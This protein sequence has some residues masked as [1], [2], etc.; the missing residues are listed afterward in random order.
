MS[1]PAWDHDADI[2]IVGGGSAGAVLAGRL[3]EDPATQVLL[4]EAGRSGR[5]PL[6]LVPGAQ[7]FVRDW[8]RHAWAYDIEPDPT[9]LGRT[10]TWRRGKSLGGSST[11][12]G[13]I[14]ARGLPSDFDRWAAAGLPQWSFEK[15]LP[16]FRRMEASADFPHSPLR[17][18]GGPVPVEVLRSA[19]VLA[20]DLLASAQ[21]MG[22]P[23][24]ADAN[25]MQGEG[26]GLAQT[27]QQR[28]LRVSSETS[29]LQPARRRQNLRVLTDATALRILFDGRR[30]EGVEIDLG[31][32]R[33]RVRA[34]R[35]TVLSAGPIASP[36]LLARSGV[37][38]G[39]ALQA[40]G[41]PVVAD[42][43]DVGAHLQDHPDVYVEY[44]VRVPTYSSAL[45]GANLVKAGLQF[46]L[47]RDGPA[48]SP[49]THVLGYLKSRP[50]EPEP[51][52][53]FFSG[54]WSRIEDGGTFTSPRAVMSM[55]PSLCR[56]RSRGCISLR[57]ADPT[58]P[59][60]IQANML[61][62]AD[63]IRRLIAGVRLADRLAMTAPLCDQVIRRLTP[64]AS[65]LDDDT[66]LEAWLRAD[67]TT[68]YHACGTCRMGADAASV[69]D[70]ELRVRGVNKLR[71]VDSSVFPEIPSG[72]LN[73]PTV[74]LA[75]R[76]ADLM[77]QAL[78]GD[79]MRES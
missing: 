22:I 2:V 8:S 36:S 54:P 56:P 77:R 47:R 65:N 39:R 44:E 37:G 25:A 61:A 53:L 57:S 58:D 40:L 78:A 30:A 24:H 76:A 41:I 35:E 42:S 73:A 50:S 17:G 60:R 49:G 51:D 20:Q 11:I 52:L 9:R 10:E 19:H 45:R 66:A 16:Y 71:V 70:A 6:F 1:T 28:G 63:D 14:F 27:N 64:D 62:D 26:L 34:R 72:N 46:L 75:E 21:R 69:V 4:I 38:P 48:T 74:M 29:H 55:S 68:C 12:N 32:R 15:L 79:V 18:D 23:I 7:V 43:P 5:H 13:L 33:R 59:P 31:G 3:S 67:A